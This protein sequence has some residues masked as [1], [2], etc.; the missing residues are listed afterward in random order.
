M[1]ETID[2]FQTW[3]KPTFIARLRH[4]LNAKPYQNWDTLHDTLTQIER[5][6]EYKESSENGMKYLVDA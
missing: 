1:P 4:N 2:A 5:E 3:R 6:I